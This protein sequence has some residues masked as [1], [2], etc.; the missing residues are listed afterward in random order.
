MEPPA[1][2][3]VATPK[4]TLLAKLEW[5]RNGGEVSE[6][7]WRDVL[8]IMMVQGNKLDLAYLRQWAK[9]LKVSDLL[10]RALLDAGR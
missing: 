10:E 4:E 2:A 1:E 5:Y 7:Q 8:G 3:L 6:R 9:E